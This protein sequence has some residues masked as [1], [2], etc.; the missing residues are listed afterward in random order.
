M[1]K[2]Q[3]Y[4][5]FN[6]LN[7]GSG[8]LPDR[9]AKT[10]YKLMTSSLKELKLVEPNYE[11]GKVSP[12]YK[13]LIENLK[14]VKDAGDNPQALLESLGGLTQSRYTI[15]NIK[16]YDTMSKVLWGTGARVEDV[17]GLRPKDIDFKNKLIYL[18]GLNKTGLQRVVPLSD[19]LA[20]VLKERI[21]DIGLDK[22]SYRAKFIF[23]SEPKTGNNK[24]ILN[25]TDYNNYLDKVVKSEFNDIDPSF[26]TGIDPDT[27]RAVKKSYLFRQGVASLVG[28]SNFSERVFL[29]QDI[30]GHTDTLMQSH[31]NDRVLKWANTPDSQLVSLDLDKTDMNTFDAFWNFNQRSKI[32]REHHIQELAYEASRKQGAKVSKPATKPKTP[33]KV[34]SEY[35]AALKERVYGSSEKFKQ[36]VVPE[37]GATEDFLRAVDTGAPLP[38]IP[39]GTGAAV[40]E[41]GT[42]KIRRQRAKRVKPES[43]H[44]AI[45][46]QQQIDDKAFSALLNKG[47]QSKVLVDL[48]MSLETGI[49]TIE[50]L[51]DQINSG[52]YMNKVDSVID[53]LI[54]SITGD[55]K[56]GYRDA[57]DYLP[58]NHKGVPSWN[59]NKSILN[60]IIPKN[61]Q[62]INPS[63]G[64]AAIRLDG[65]ILRELLETIE[66]NNR[67][68]TIAKK[69]IDQFDYLAT[70]ADIADDYVAR[71]AYAVDKMSVSIDKFVDDK[72][73][74]GL[75]EPTLSIAFDFKQG[76]VETPKF[77]SDVANRLQ[78]VLLEQ[79]YAPIDAADI[80]RIINNHTGIGF[81]EI[82]ERTAGKLAN[83]DNLINRIRIQPYL[84]TLIE[85]EV[86]D[87]VVY[88]R[89]K[90][91]VEDVDFDKPFR[92]KLKYKK[93]GGVKATQKN[94]TIDVRT[95]FF[96]TLLKESMPSNILTLTDSDGMEYTTRAPIIDY[97]DAE[98]K[99][100]QMKTGRFS[101]TF[102]DSTKLAGKKFGPEILKGAVIAGFGILA[103][104]ALTAAEVATEVAL[105]FPEDFEKSLYRTTYDPDNPKAEPGGFVKTPIDVET[106]TLSTGKQLPMTVDRNALDDFLDTLT[107]EEIAEYEDM[108][109]AERMGVEPTTGG[110]RLEGIKAGLRVGTG[111]SGMS[112]EEGWAPNI[113][114]TLTEGQDYSRQLR[115]DAERDVEVGITEEQFEDSAGALTG[116]PIAGFGVGA[117]A[118]RV[119]Q[120]TQGQQNVARADKISLAKGDR[121]L[122]A[123]KDITAQM[124]NLNLLTNQKGEDNAVNE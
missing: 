108:N 95:N 46:N 83:S 59:K 118:N 48:P 58:F 114:Q 123:V 100:P 15:E 14:K 49:Q 54:T 25:S 112:K 6:Y 91:F 93:D 111:E 12:Y 67:V 19:N 47:S 23:S 120:K 56:I 76:S 89:G 97:V 63:T 16:K 94:Y 80:E 84:D 33:A 102:I 24:T 27:N 73:M 105:I 113:A 104:P 110:Y 35:Q 45:W 30:L 78:G 62:R 61:L 4:Q 86:L 109:I 17:N 72:F 87:N 53:D 92:E 68:D 88:E 79:E 26:F 31:Y 82:D 22:P 121:D 43:R 107:P 42:T 34:I 21:K 101:D 71:T 39:P 7:A 81:S 116:L 65:N 69:L 44:F 38:E 29:V 66:Y 99:T 52:E 115:R 8:N 32:V 9:A 11:I 51:L 75:D 18:D 74:A 20:K 98:G 55:P 36:N 3:T 28:N 57:G 1:A 106:P 77:M 50:G 90:E 122:N 5:A 124:S 70:P 64:A 41:G 40:I 103:A 85:L 10:N 37:G 117:L 13:G 2:S 119:D 60:N 96:G